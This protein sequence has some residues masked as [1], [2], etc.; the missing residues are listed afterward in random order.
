MTPR[1][2][3]ERET[4]NKTAELIATSALEEIAHESH[5]LKS[6]LHNLIG[7]CQF[8]AR[9]P[10]SSPERVGLAQETIG[11]LE[12]ALDSPSY[13]PV[14]HRVHA[15]RLI[16]RL[17]CERGEWKKAY[18]ASVTAVSFIPKITPRSIRNADK[19]RLLSAD[20]VAGF[21]AHAVAA[22]LNAGEDGYAALHLQEMGRGSLAAS[23]AELRADIVELR[24]KHPDLTKRLFRCRI[25]SRWDPTNSMG[26][27]SS[28]TIC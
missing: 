16:I 9:L 1:R 14:Y 20:D 21:G 17:C 15:E 27:I 22:A 26:Q 25:S 8:Y 23:V 4:L 10:Q 5:L 3:E 28:L 18:D 13:V 19:Q 12:K 6:H 2:G 7:L 11:H 24:R